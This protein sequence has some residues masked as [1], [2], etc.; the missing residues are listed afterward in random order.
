MDSIIIISF[1]EDNSF[2]S[3]T[4][5]I[6]IPKKYFTGNKK[7]RIYL[8]DEWRFI[9]CHFKSR[10]FVTKSIFGDK[11]QVSRNYNIVTFTHIDA[12]GRC[13][14]FYVHLY[15]DPMRTIYE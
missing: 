3:S 9:N 2:G 6:S 11:I 7:F 14:T 12:A 8:Q 10:V 13:S 15:D 5:N 1:Y 4:G